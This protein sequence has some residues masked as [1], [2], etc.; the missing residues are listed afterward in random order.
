MQQST[1]RSPIANPQVYCISIGNPNKQTSINL[2]Y[3]HHIIYNIIKHKPTTKNK[4]TQSKKPYQKN[5]NKFQNTTTKTTNNPYEYWTNNPFSKPYQKPNKPYHMVRFIKIEISYE[6]SKNTQYFAV[7][8]H[9]SYLVGGVCNPDF[10]VGAI[11][12][13]PSGIHTV[14]FLIYWSRFSQETAKMPKTK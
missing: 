11:R 6:I 5:K 14:D 13:M 3:H 4:K 2:P 10:S 1:I 9:L 12:G 7:N 8:C